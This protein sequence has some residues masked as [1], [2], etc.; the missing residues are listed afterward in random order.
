MSEP[1]HRTGQWKRRLAAGGPAPTKLIF[2][3]RFEDLDTSQPIKD[4]DMLEFAEKIKLV[5]KKGLYLW[6]AHAIQKLRAGHDV[7]IKAGTGSGKSLPVQ[8]MALSRPDAVVLVVSPLLAL[9]DNQVDTIPHQFADCSR[10]RHSF[11][12]LTTSLQSP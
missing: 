11:P 1:P 6:Q 12:R 4:V 3:P 2:K 5:F 10:W 7:M 8:A 9:M